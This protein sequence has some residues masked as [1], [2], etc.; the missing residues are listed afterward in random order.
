MT[1]R[2]EIAAI[3]TRM[4]SGSNSFITGARCIKDL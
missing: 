3:A 1:A 2:D 4:L